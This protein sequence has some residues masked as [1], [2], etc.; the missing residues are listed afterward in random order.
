M[1]FFE[2]IKK[3]RSVRAYKDK[4]VEEEK[5]KKI[6]DTC[7]SAPSAGNLQAYEIF[8]VKSIEKRKA[9]A[10]AAY[11]QDFIIEAPVS[12]VFFANPK[13]NMDRYRKRGEELYS[14]Q[15]ATIAASFAML[16]AVEL[17][18]SSVWVGAFD[19]D[20]VIKIFG[21]KELRPVAILPIGYSNEEPIKTP[22]RK[23]II[24][25]E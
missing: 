24:H 23:D 15:D 9:L 1:D 2:L 16:A 3:R 25:Y 11:G 7:L 10:K 5:L 6:I 14:I 22:R 20:S 19:D 4:T 18:L 8:V 13:R 12:L 17:E 21:L